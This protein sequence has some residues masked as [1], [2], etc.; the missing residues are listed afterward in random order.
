MQGLF[1]YFLA[2][3]L[4][5]ISSGSTSSSVASAFITNHKN[6][7]QVNTMHSP[8]VT[9]PCSFHLTPDDPKAM[10][11]RSGF[12]IHGCQCCTSGDHTS[13]PVDGCSAGCLIINQEERE[14]LRVGD[15]LQV[16]SYESEE[17]KEEAEAAPK[18]EVKQEAPAH[19]ESVHKQV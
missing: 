1:F 14:K 19:D 8:P 12:L 3:F 7:L 10:C 5:F 4:C 11:G 17:E 6:I 16:I 13:P 2:V 9:K 18:L 15:K